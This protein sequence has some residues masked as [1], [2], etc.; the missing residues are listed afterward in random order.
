[1][2]ELMGRDPIKDALSVRERAYFA[3]ALGH[4]LEQEYGSAQK[5]L[6]LHSDDGD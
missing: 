6:G 3:A 4:Y 2:Y 5:Q 1:M